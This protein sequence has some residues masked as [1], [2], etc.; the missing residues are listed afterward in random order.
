MA[1]LNRFAMKF[2][3]K[4]GLF[5]TETLV[6]VLKAYGNGNLNRSNVFMWYSRFRNGRELVEDVEGGRP[7]STGTELNIAAVADL[8]KNDRLIGSRMMAE[9]SNIPKTVV[10]RILKNYL[11]K[12]K[13]FSCCAIMRPPT[14]LQVFANF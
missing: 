9:S 13:I 8:V 12:R 7:I 1:E 3:C 5:A 4:S 11:G 14:K 2:C 6:L 10:L